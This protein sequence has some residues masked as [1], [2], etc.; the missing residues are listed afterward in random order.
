MLIAAAPA[1]ATPVTTEAE[2][3]SLPPGSGQG[4]SGALKILSTATATGTVASRATR[5]ITVRARG[6]QCG[7]APRM[8]VSVDGRV[9]LDVNVGATAWT[10]YAADLPLADGTHSVTV[11]FDNDYRSA[12]C[13]RNLYVDRVQLTS[14]AARPLPG[15][16]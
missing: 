5:R 2:T 3:L 14:V 12:T 13:D 4:A 15:A 10:D 8:I 16:A 7:G 11:R 1:A 9:A 6:E